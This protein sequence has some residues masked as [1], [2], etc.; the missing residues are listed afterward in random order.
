MKFCVFAR[1]FPTPHKARFVWS[2]KNGQRLAGSIATSIAVCPPVGGH[3]LV[4]GHDPPHFVR[5]WRVFITPLMFAQLT[6]R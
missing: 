4:P 2:S 3:Y 1:R 6:Y 5:W